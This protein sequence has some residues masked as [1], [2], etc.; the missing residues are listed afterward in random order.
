M[1]LGREA[2]TVC[3]QDLGGCAADRHLDG[4]FQLK[5]RVCCIGTQRYLARVAVQLTVQVIEVADDLDGL[6]G[7]LGHKRAHA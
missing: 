1:R 7:L 4:R 3:G 5:G 2:G 6:L